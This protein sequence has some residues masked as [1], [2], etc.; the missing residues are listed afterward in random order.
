MIQKKRR[1]DKITKEDFEGYVKMEKKEER[2][3]ICPQSIPAGPGGLRPCIH[4]NCMA[5]RSLRKNC[6]LID[7]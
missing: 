1:V 7:P 3:R 5:W 6:K 2:M 4:E